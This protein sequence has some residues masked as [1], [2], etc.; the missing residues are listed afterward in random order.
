MRTDSCAG[1]LKD[2]DGKTAGDSAVGGQQ[3]PNGRPLDPLYMRILCQGS[4]MLSFESDSLRG[5]STPV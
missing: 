2:K 4:G 3:T 5:W 1:P